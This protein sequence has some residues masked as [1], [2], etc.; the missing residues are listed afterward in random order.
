MVKTWFNEH[1][2]HVY[3]VRSL[4]IYSFLAFQINNMLFLDIVVSLMIVVI[5][6][7]HQL[8]LVQLNYLSNGQ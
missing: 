1:Q 7:N 2:V 8:S 6:V 3:I 5:N 4:F